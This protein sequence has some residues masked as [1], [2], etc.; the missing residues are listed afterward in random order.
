MGLYDELTA[1]RPSDRLL[2]DTLQRLVGQVARSSSFPPPE[3]FERWDDNA[4]LDVVTQLYDAGPSFVTMCWARAGNDGSLERLFLTT[5]R[6]FLIDQAKGTGTGKLRR[7]LQRLVKKD[8][9]VTAGKLATGEDAWWL[10]DSPAAPWF[11]DVA[12]LERAAGRVRGVRVTALNPPGPNGHRPDEGRER[13]PR[14]GGWCRSCAGRHPHRRALLG[15]VPSARHQVPGRGRPVE[16]TPGDPVEQTPELDGGTEVGV[17]ASA[18]MI[19]ESLNGVERVACAHL[20]EHEDGLGELLGVGRREAAVV[21]K[22]L[23]AKMRSGCTTRTASAEAAAV[24]V[25]QMCT[26]RQ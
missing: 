11:G 5:I 14:R 15:A 9:A 18:E 2:M 1:G 8:A 21:A 10:T 3:G 25:M 19:W 6:N 22:R 12:E 24:R 7:R 17:E 4:A 23:Q 20:A 13:G 16:Q 26:E